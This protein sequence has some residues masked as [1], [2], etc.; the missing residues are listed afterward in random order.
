[1]MKTTAI[2]LVKNGTSDQAFR[3]SEITLPEL[4]DDEVQIEVES[5]GLNYADVMAR[6]GLYREAPPIPCVLGYEVVGKV[7]TVG[8]EAP[9]ELKEKRVVAFTRFGGYAKHVNTK[10]IAV[11]EIGD[12][13]SGKALC[14]ATQYVTAFYMSHVATTVQKGDRVLIHAAAG[15]VG[16]ALIQL[17]KGRGATIFAKTGSD[18][19]KPYLEDLGVDHII[20]YNKHDYSDQIQ[21][22]LK[23]ER[24][25]ISFNPVAGA[26]FKKDWRLLGNGG[27]L[28]LFG[29]S[30]RSGKKWGILST[31]NFVRKMGIIIPITLMMRSKSIVGI[32][33]LKVGDYKPFTM[34]FC[35][36]SVVEKALNNEINPK[37]GASYTADKIAE[38]HAFLESGKSTGKVVVEW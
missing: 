32:N 26:T 13:D 18:S 25:D 27:S 30:E 33:M 28:V 12:Y 4:E 21:Y 24:L 35:L 22:Y 6:N 23:R 15:G 16:T 9:D 36:K 14:L 8:K 31:L 19:K 10:Y 3:E 38:A 17:L 7:I 11:A 20:N 34:E 37:V 29:G 1:M 2:Q 5:F